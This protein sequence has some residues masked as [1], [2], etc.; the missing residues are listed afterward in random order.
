VASCSET[1]DLGLV[2]VAPPLTEK[3]LDLGLSRAPAVVVVVVAVVVGRIGDEGAVVG[4]ALARRRERF[5]AGSAVL[6]SVV[7]EEAFLSWVL[8]SWTREE[9]ERLSSSL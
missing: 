2:L 3:M 7:V 9:E 4:R 8:G 6:A 5:A 1:A